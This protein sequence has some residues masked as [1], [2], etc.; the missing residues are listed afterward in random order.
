MNSLIETA[1]LLDRL[2]S[3]DLRVLDVRTVI[4]NPQGG[5]QMYQHSHIPGALHVDLE[6]D[7][8]GT[9]QPGVTGRHPLP[10]ATQLIEKIQGWGISEQ[11]QV[12][13]YGAHS[14]MF[15]ARLWWSLA[16]WM[17]HRHTTVLH[18]GFHAWQ[19][20][21]LPVQTEPSE[22]PRTT[23]RPCPQESAV[24]QAS[25]VLASADGGTALLDARG[26]ERY[27]G[28]RERLDSVTGHIPGAVC[29]SAAANIDDDGYFVDRET[30]ARRF[31][32]WGS[33][34]AISYCGSGL[35]ACHNIL[36]MQLCGYR[37]PRL[38]AGSWSEWITDPH[39][40]IAYGPTSD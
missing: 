15:A 40:K 7:L 4:S 29:C 30:L 16:A 18:G 36:A 20:A 37:L 14:D 10:P 8:C 13:V 35:N 31:G 1:Q 17:N 34:A 22:Y 21:G 2:H 19:K 39:R 38:Y 12:V 32:K 11:T 5:R 9:I 6:R 28:D 24:A 26:Y 25:D 33:C 23:Y 3:K 27:C